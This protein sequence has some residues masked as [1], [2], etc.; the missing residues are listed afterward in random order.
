MSGLL[1]WFDVFRCGTHVDRFGR[2]VTVTEDDID[3]AIS[4]YEKD[5]APIVVGHPAL[6]SPAYGWIGAFRR[7]G[8]VV[9]A[10][11]SQVAD[12]FADLVQRR[13]YKNRSL[14]FGPGLKFRHVGFLGAQ[15]PA[16]KGLKDIQFS[17]EEDYMTVEFS[18]TANTPAADAETAA[19]PAADPNPSAAPA[20]PDAEAAQSGK[21]EEAEAETEKP[22]DQPA[23]SDE[24]AAL[25]TELEAAKAAAAK[26]QNELA[27]VKTKQRRAEFAEFTGALVKSGQLPQAQ[28]TSVCDFMECLDSAGTYE[29]AEGAEP[30]LD[31]FKRLLNTLLTPVEFAEVAVSGTAAAPSKGGA[32]AYAERI[33]A[34]RAE[35]T[36]LGR[37]VNASEAMAH[38]LGGNHDQ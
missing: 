13:L 31:R 16:V 10:K 22:H 9:Q 34:Y 17:D 32:Q 36:K 28:Q 30:V 38:I 19:P 5:S 21:D 4:S 12:E 6:N 26:L 24:M 18:E 20:Q 8:D 2:E 15:P 37:H 33:C 3:R 14:A 25:K 29:F 27:Q 11:A 1:D 23:G 35:Q 7:V